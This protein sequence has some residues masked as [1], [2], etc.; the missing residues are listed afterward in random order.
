MSGLEVVVVSSTTVDIVIPGVPQHLSGHGP[1]NWEDMSQLWNQLRTPR[2]EIF[3][4]PLRISIQ[5]E[6]SLK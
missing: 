4:D 1:P 3:P 5:D 6:K 2:H